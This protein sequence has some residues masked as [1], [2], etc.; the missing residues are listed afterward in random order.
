MSGMPTPTSD[1]G[2]QATI[3]LVILGTSPHENVLRRSPQIDVIRARQA[4][5]AV[6]E[7]GYA[8]EQHADQRIVLLLTS[9]SPKGQSLQD[10]LA[11]AKLVVPDLR[12]LADAE[13]SLEPGVFEESLPSDGHAAVRCVLASSGT[14]SAAPKQA[15]AP[16]VK[17]APLAKEEPQS[18]M[19]AAGDTSEAPVE[20][21]SSDVVESLLRGR[22]ILEPAL[23]TLREMLDGLDIRFVPAKEHERPAQ[24]SCVEVS[25]GR[26]VFG[27]L[28][29]IPNDDP[30]S[31]DAARWFASW[32]ALSEQH[33]Q[34]QA[35]ALTDELTG[36]WNRRY[37]LRY[38]DQAIEQARL[39]R[40]DLTIMLYD[41]DNFK[42]Y[43]DTYGHSAGDEILTETVRLLQSCIRPTDRVCRIGG[44]EFAVI[45]DDPRGPRSNDGKH[46][47]SLAE[48]A[49]RFQ[50]QICM[51]RF[52]KLGPEAESTLTISGGMA[53][54]PW[55]AHDAASL[56]ERADALA[57]ESKRQGKG[58]ITLGP[59]AETVCRLRFHE[60]FDDPDGV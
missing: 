48:I 29:G 21:P 28:V 44:D 53:T 31:G 49:E 56:I 37:C 5:D 58:L 16:P 45:F 3:C 32:L 42:H 8:S 46:P 22:S 41:L 14:R 11:A 20:A 18:V 60:D 2:A 33:R 4:N 54:Y 6:G 7:L 38:L 19:P 24:G 34:L 13:T 9:E 25:R 23:I 35:A 15:P 10:F 57:L 50:R 12:V 39:Q 55:D 43:N 59:G 52:P 30:R 27:W 47:T 36:A 40:R 17:K 51:H 26:V 1:A